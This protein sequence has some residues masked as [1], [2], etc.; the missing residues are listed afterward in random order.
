MPV[1][2]CRLPAAL[3]LLAGLAAAAGGARAE[4]YQTCTGFIDS[5]PATI[6]TQGVWCLRKDLSTAMTSGTAI[7]IATNNVTI[8]CNDF[9]IGGLAAGTASLTHGITA[10]ERA[11]AVVRHCNVR[12]FMYGIHLRGYG[13]LVEDNRFDNNLVQGIH[14]EGHDSIVRR[15]RVLDTGG[16]P[17]SDRSYGIFATGDVVDNIVSGVYAL[18]T[19]PRVRGIYLVGSRATARGN[20][21]RD[22]SASAGS[23]AVGLLVQGGGNA[24]VDNQVSVNPGHEGTGISAGGITSA[25]C[26]GNFVYGFATG[27]LN[28]RDGGGNTVL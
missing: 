22:L 5:I 1:P 21:V 6:T 23:V 15:N 20:R 10:G 7:T 9:K 13:H 8:D 4:T 12:G 16:Y 2:S 25:A 17:A 19:S 3:A 11:N 27:I 28:C 26:T 18:G 14:V 24:V